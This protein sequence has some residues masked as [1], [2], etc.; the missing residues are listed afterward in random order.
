MYVWERRQKKS[1]QRQ[2]HRGKEGQGESLTSP[3]M[4]LSLFSEKW[5]TTES[6]RTEKKNYLFTKCFLLSS[7]K[8]LVTQ[9]CLTLCDPTDS[10]SPGSSV[11]GILQARILV[12]G[13]ISFSRWFFPTQGQN[14]GLLHCRQ[15][16][17]HLS[18]QGSPIYLLSI[19]SGGLI[20]VSSRLSAEAETREG[21]LLITRQ[22]PGEVLCVHHLHP[23]NLHHTPVNKCP[24]LHEETK[25]SLE[26]LH[27][28]KAVAKISLWSVL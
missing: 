24:L 23:S 22:G 16:P 26:R 25:G 2:S 27:C 8:V 4:A 13:A 14:L 17:Y 20:L 5:E 28:P 18:H 7:H 19:Y 3:W 10:S 1:N 11:P 6:V 12:W 9:L 21:A 15:I